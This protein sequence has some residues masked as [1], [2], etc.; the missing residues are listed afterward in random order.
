[1]AA[2]V[3][4]DEQGVFLDALSTVL[5]QS[6]HT[7]LGAGRNGPAVVELVR[8]HRP[9]ICLLDRRFVNCD[10]GHLISPL[11]Q[12]SPGTRVMILSAEHDLEGMRHALSA[13]AVGYLHKSRGVAAL[14]AAINQVLSGQ[15]AVDLPDTA[16]RANTCAAV[17]EGSRAAHRLAAHLTP[18]EREC[19]RLLADG[20]DTSAIMGKLGVSRT[21]VRSH[22]QAVLFKLGVHSRLQAVSL[23]LRHG[24]LDEAPQAA[25][26][27]SRSATAG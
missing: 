25:G 16:S 6:G 23:A 24:L 17:D 11:R 1:V 21:T 4:G 18:R 13:G 14:I 7:V 26:G 15:V 12:A 19:L 20:L 22:I 27:S 8:E 10:G 9:D 2:L 5:H 3:L